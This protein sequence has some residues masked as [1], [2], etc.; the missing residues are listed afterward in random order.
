MEEIGYVQLQKSNFDSLL[1]MWNFDLSNFLSKLNIL[2]QN[3]NTEKYEHKPIASVRT[4]QHFI[5]HIH[6]RKKSKTPTNPHILA[7]NDR[8]NFPYLWTRPGR[9]G[10]PY[11]TTRPSESHFFCASSSFRIPPPTRSRVGGSGVALRPII[12]RCAV[13][14]SR[15]PR[16]SHVCFLSCNFRDLYTVRVSGSVEVDVDGCWCF[17]FS[18]VWAYVKVSSLCSRIAT[19]RLNNADYCCSPDIVDLLILF[20]FWSVL[21]IMVGSFSS[22]I[23]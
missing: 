4:H 7:F 6:P 16:F 5:I 10:P 18:F 13:Q 9:N 15:K 2:I 11:S 8:G 3:F 1:K 21:F 23:I 20:Q 14:S 19:F 22:S 12:P 17:G